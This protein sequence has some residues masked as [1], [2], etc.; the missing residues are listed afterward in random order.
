[1]S[2]L[3]CEFILKAHVHA[4]HSPQWV[5]RRYITAMDGPD[6]DDDAALDMIREMKGYALS[7]FNMSSTDDDLL[8]TLI[9]LLNF[10][11]R[12]RGGDS[13]VAIVTEMFRRP[14]AASDLSM[15]CIASGRPYER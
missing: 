9:R 14:N 13:S 10:V 6:Q 4:L 7:A 15:P 1:M 8:R 2:Y 11:H 5:K 12:S 3:L